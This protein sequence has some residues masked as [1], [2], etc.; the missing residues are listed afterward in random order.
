MQRVAIIGGMLALAQP[1]AAAVTDPHRDPRVGDCL[2]RDGASK[3]R[4]LYRFVVFRDGMRVKF[5]TSGDSAE[6]E[7]WLTSWQDWASSADI[8][9]RAAS[10][11]ADVVQF[12]QLVGV[13]DK[14]DRRPV[15]D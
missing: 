12:F 5:M 3:A 4:W 9:Q 7:V 11:I 6:R 10:G 1:S 13:R 8:E 15:R 2:K 14:K